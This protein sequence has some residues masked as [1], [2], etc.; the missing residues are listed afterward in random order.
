M[1]VVDTAA[2]ERNRSR[3]VVERT[4]AVSDAAAQL[5]YHRAVSTVQADECGRGVVPVTSMEAQIGKPLSAPQIIARLQRCNPRLY[6]EKSNADRSKVGI[7][8]HAADNQKRFIM[9]MEAGFSPEFSVRHTKKERMPHPTERG[10]WVEAEV[11]ERETR[12]W[13][14]VLARLVRERLITLAQVKAHFPLGRTS[15]NWHKAT[16]GAA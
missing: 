7:Y 5:A 4:R 2:Q 12:G 6:F 3:A 9:G 13:R 10:Q 15:K 16:K 8:T 1:L 11:F 14:T